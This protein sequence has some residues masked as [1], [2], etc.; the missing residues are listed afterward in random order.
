MQKLVGTMK[1]TQGVTKRNKMPAFVQQMNDM[2]GSAVRRTPVVPTLESYA[3]DN[4]G[5]EMSLDDLAVTTPDPDDMR[6]LNIDATH[7]DM[8]NYD[9]A[10]KAKQYLK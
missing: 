5:A 8:D 10:A 1:L 6:G 3:F 7:P 2:N 9:N 4:R